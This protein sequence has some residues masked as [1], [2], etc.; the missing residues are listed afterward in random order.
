MEISDRTAD[1]MR[2]F[3]AAFANATDTEADFMLPPAP[4]SDGRQVRDEAMSLLEAL[5]PADAT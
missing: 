3:I 5:T 2:Q 4:H 1:R